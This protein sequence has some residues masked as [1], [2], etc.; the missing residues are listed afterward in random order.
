MGH[1]YERTYPTNRGVRTIY[2][3]EINDA[4]PKR[5]TV[6]SYFGGVLYVVTIPMEDQ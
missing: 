5:S 6:D 1:F 3:P 4:A 2:D